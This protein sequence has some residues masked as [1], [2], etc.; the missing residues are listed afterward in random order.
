MLQASL[1][2]LN[3]DLKNKCASGQQKE[4]PFAFKGA[5]FNYFDKIW[6]FLT[7]YLH[8]VNI[9]EGIPIGS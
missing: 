7:T 1:V 3:D 6:S 9:S 4:V 2:C 8:W 5:I